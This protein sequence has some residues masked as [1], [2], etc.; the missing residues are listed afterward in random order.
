[1]CL[2]LPQHVKLPRGT[3]VSLHKSCELG[4]SRLLVLVPL[5]LVLCHG[6]LLLLRV[7]LLVLSRLLTSIRPWLLIAIGPIVSRSA[8][9]LGSRLLPRVT[10][11][12]NRVAC[13]RVFQR[14]V[15][16]FSI[17]TCTVIIGRL[18]AVSC[19]SAAVA[20][21]TSLRSDRGRQARY[22]TWTSSNRDFSG[23]LYEWHVFR[24]TYSS[25]GLSSKGMQAMAISCSGPLIKTRHTGAC[26]N[27]PRLVPSCRHHLQWPP[28]HT[29]LPR[30]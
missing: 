28:L 14:L 5:A 12:C 22:A 16:G 13:S 10:A 21:Q 29:A 3:R 30:P 17:A 25:P 2:E 27:S 7:L 6:L 23:D 4:D 24:E 19:S 11:T 20:F 8:L 1:M 15:S 26:N 9:C 18:V